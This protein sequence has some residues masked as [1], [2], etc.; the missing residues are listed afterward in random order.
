MEETMIGLPVTVAEILQRFVR[1]V[2]R[3]QP[4]SQTPAQ[5]ATAHYDPNTDSFPPAVLKRMRQ[6]AINGLRQDWQR[7]VSDAEL[8]SI[9]NA[10]LR[11]AMNDV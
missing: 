6:H 2:F 7:K 1:R 8:D 3:F 10:A 11:E 9:S 4:V 5:F